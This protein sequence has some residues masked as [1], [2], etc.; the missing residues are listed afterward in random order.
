[1][2]DVIPIVGRQTRNRPA[3]R[4][5][6]P[7]WRSARNSPQGE[8]IPTP[9]ITE[10]DERAWYQHGWRDS[11]HAV[12][13][14]ETLGI[15][16]GGSPLPPALHSALALAPDAH[17]SADYAA[18]D[19]LSWE[20]TTTPGPDGVVHPHA[21][22]IF[23]NWV[24]RSTGGGHVANVHLRAAIGWLVWRGLNGEVVRWEMGRARAI[25]LGLPDNR[26]ATFRQL[27]FR[28]EYAE[29]WRTEMTLK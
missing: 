12:R 17:T 9:E 23:T 29:A 25:D 22:A 11:R 21:A 27:W 24:A 8:Q 14:L 6:R 15:R 3:G 18:I 10:R 20:L 26:S 28:R 1:M 2:I 13:L 5:E 7:R 19:A 4:G 16:A